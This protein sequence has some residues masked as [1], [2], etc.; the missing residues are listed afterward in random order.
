MEYLIKV[1]TVISIFYICYKLFLQRDTFFES[2][3]WF[4]LFGL[5][6]A[7]TIPYFVI[8]VYIEITAVTLPEYPYGE[9]TSNQNL[10][11]KSFDWLNILLA[12]Y[13]FGVLFFSCR[14]AIQI[15][16]LLN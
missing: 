15:N 3:R 13:L 10:Q 2:N 4:L 6:T 14:F 12:T 7:F 5:I 11:S 8:P 1:S 9:I 16:S